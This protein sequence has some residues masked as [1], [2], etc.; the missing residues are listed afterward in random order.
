MAN[1]SQLLCPDCGVGMN[2]HAEKINYM[3]AP[4]QSQYIDPELDGV[5]EEIHACP[6]CGKAHAR[7]LDDGQSD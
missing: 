4:E 6:V 1:E 3:V 7:P 5:L 2:R